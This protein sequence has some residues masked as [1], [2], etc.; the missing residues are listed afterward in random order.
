MKNIA[1]ELGLDPNTDENGILAALR[2]LKNRGDISAA[3]LAILRNEHKTFGE[4]NQTLLG[5][6]VD[7]ILAE[8][9]ITDTKIVNRL[10]PVLLPL[11]NRAERLTFL[12]DLGHKPEAKAAPAA[13]TGRV[14]N[15][16]TASAAATQAGSNAAVTTAASLNDEVRKVM[17][18]DRSNFD[19]AFNVLRREKPELFA[20]P[21][22][23]DE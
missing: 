21:I 14:L 19:T 6:Q 5:E 18:R 1:V 22:A 17:N 7:G 16:G 3:D 23:Q 15:R 20:A 12:A 2:P 11:A 8:H 9:K 10:K 4:Q 13:T